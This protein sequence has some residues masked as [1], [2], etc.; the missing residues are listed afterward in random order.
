M[1]R[2]AAAS[3]AL[4][5]ANAFAVDPAILGSELGVEPSKEIVEQR[6]FK[7]IVVAPIPISNPT[8]GTGLAV[9]AMPFYNLE[10][11]SPLSN[12]AVAVGLTSNGSW[13]AAAVQSTRLRGDTARIDGTVAYGEVHYRFYGAGADAGAGGQS[14]PIVQK[15]ALFAP[16][17]LF[18]VAK[19]TFA[20]LRYRGLRVETVLEDGNSSL[21]PPVAAVLPNSVTIV[22]SGIGPKLTYDSRDNEMNPASGG[23]VELRTNFADEALGSDFTYQTYQLGANYYGKLGRGVLAARGY[24]C[25]ASDRTPLFDLC[26]YGANRD[27]RGYVTGRYRDRTMFAAQSEYRFPVAGRFGGVVFAGSGKVAGAFSE[28]GNEPWL[29]SYGVGVRWLAAETAKVNLSVDVAKGR[30]STGVYV[31]VKESF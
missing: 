17:I 24:G 21:P 26:L 8:V 18:Q 23:L 5:A 19:Y 7:D 20:G 16:E 25:K 14:V 2:L 6:A 10:R 28:M 11:D 27:L 3:I 12:T 1:L 4:A 29:P 9:V 22:S 15:V 30:D 13:G 31:Y